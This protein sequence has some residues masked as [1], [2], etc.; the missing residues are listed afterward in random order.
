MKL[1]TF[2]RRPR[3]VELEEQGGKL[4]RSAAGRAAPRA[5]RRA[6]RAADK[7]GAGSDLQA[8]LQLAYGVFPPGYLKRAVLVTDGVETEATCWP[9]PTARAASG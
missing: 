2:A 9:R 7:P 4:V 5:H 3:L 1:V 8:A 6:A